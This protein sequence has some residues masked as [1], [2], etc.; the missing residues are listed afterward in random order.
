MSQHQ[1]SNR[2]DDTLQGEPETKRI[3]C[4]NCKEYTHHCL[5]ARYSRPDPRS[6]GEVE[7]RTSIWSC[8]GCDQETFEWRFAYRDDD[9][10]SLP[11]F[12]FPEREGD[13]IPKTNDVTSDSEKIDRMV[14]AV[15]SFL[16]EWKQEFDNLE[17]SLKATQMEIVCQYEQNRRSATSYEPCIIA[18]LG[19]QLYSRLHEMTQRALQLGEYH[20]NINQE[21]DGFG[22]TALKTAKA[23]ENELIL[24]V[25]WPVVTELQA[26]GTDSYD[27]QGISKEPLIL[28]GKVPKRSMTL[29]NAARYLRK[30]SVMRSK[31][32]ALGFDVLTV[33][34]EAAL[35]AE[36]RNRAAHELACDRAVADDLRQRILCPDGALSRLHPSAATA[37]GD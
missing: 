21:P 11:C 25:I 24:R 2:G 35:I 36:I 37:T 15:Q 27:G 6:K 4:N 26:A 29:G 12:Y 33:S 1:R 20:Y 5:R 28:S 14:V 10:D 30:D 18:K 7:V 17:D 22:E 31:V 23:Y 32:S 9:D 8:A 19:T 13:S 34:K 16:Q 3:L